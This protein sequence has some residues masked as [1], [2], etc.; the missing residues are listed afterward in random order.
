LDILRAPAVLVILSAA[1][2]LLSQ[3]MNH[4]EKQI[5]RRCAPKNDIDLVW[6]GLTLGLTASRYLR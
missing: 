4:P 6:A 3:C 2:D 1:K 5:L